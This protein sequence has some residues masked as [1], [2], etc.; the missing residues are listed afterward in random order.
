MKIKRQGKKQGF[1]IGWKDL[2]LYG[3]LFLF[4]L[5]LTIGLGDFSYGGNN[6]SQN[7]SL[8]Q[9]I[10]DIK[11]NKVKEFIV[12]DNKIDVIYKDDKKAVT[13]KEPGTSLY[14]VLKDS[15]TDASKIK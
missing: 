4:L 8:S 9:A 15:N 6:S 2:I 12:S 5:F 1:R 13:K 7:I 3:F 14:E 10:S 11:N